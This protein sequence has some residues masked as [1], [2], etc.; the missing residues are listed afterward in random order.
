MNLKNL[1]R[2]VCNSTIRNMT[3]GIINNCFEDK[4][5]FKEDDDDNEP[6]LTSIFF[7]IFVLIFSGIY[8]M[9]MLVLWFRIIYYAFNTSMSEGICSIFVYQLYALYKMGTFINHYH[10]NQTIK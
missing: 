8:F 1:S 9:S 7:L 2:T 5:H 4:D 10:T 3:G 6:Q